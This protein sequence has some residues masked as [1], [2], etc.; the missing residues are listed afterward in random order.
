MFKVKPH[1]S[2]QKIDHKKILSVQ[3]LDFFFSF[4]LRGN[5]LL[6]RFFWKV[7]NMFICVVLG[8]S[9]FPKQ[10]S[11]VLSSPLSS[12]VPNHSCFFYCSTVLSRGREKDISNAGKCSP[13]LEGHF[14]WQFA[15]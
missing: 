1:V 4:A 3:V 15:G 5:A 7:V 2:Y 12:Y 13:V 10:C 6:F 8:S 9:L 11:Q 14:A